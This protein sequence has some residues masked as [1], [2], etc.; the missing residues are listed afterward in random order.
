MNAHLI[1]MTD[2]NFRDTIE[3]AHAPV[4]VDF[5]AP[6]CGP[7]RAVG[8]ILEELAEEYAGQVVIAKVNTD[9]SPL[10]PIHFGV[11]GIPTMVLFHDGQEIDRHVGALPK[12]SLRQWLNATLDGVA[13]TN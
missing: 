6:W 2:E 1:Q 9:Q 8:P 10:T 11:R 13:V 7:C 5:W 4:L 3:S 12:E